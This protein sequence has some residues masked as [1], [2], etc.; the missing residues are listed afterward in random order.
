MTLHTH[1]VA[2]A[3]EVVQ[4]GLQRNPRRPGLLPV[5]REP[6]AH[7]CL[8]PT[9]KGILEQAGDVVGH[10]AVD[11]ILKV[12]H[13]GVRRAEHQVARHVIAVHQHPGLGQG[14]VD[15]QCAD[16]L[17]GGLLRLAQLD[18]QMPPHIPLG[19]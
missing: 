19:E 12:Q 2:G 9:E 1:Q 14:A 4:L 10:R 18:A 16:A 17:P 11:R 5:T 13:P 6:A 8:G 3:Q 15:Q 7:P